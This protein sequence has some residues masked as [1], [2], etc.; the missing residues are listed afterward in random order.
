LLSR[1]DRMAKVKKQYTDSVRHQ[2]ELCPDKVVPPA[3]LAHIKAEIRESIR[4]ENNR[5]N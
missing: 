1:R 3:T 2:R 5:Y 4:R